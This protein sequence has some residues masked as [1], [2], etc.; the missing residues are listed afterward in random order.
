V[1]GH[2]T[3]SGRGHIKADPTLENSGP[4]APVQSKVMREAKIGSKEYHLASYATDA[5]DELAEVLT[6]DKR[7]FHSKPDSTA[8]RE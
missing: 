8:P 2:V 5:I 3:R 6:G 1:I 7:H 4:D